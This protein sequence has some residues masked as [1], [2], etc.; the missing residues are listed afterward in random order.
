MAEA[1]A[2]PLEPR[3]PEWGRV[4][5]IPWDTE[6]FGFLVAVYQ[7]GEPA[8]LQGAL[9]ALG[10]RLREWA[11]AQR[12]ELVSS[13]VPADDR[14][15]PKR[16]PPMK[17]DGPL[18]VGAAG[19]H[20]PIGYRVESYTPGV[21]LAFRFTAPEGFDGTHRFEVSPI[22]SGRARSTAHSTRRHRS[23]TATAPSPTTRWRYS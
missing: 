22:D 13:V 3:H 11:S 18:A 10:E 21:E 12:V 23:R 19:G 14:L 15:W 17:L 7:P 9:A 5:V 16:W 4:F 8:V 6:I 20:G 2:E 1:S